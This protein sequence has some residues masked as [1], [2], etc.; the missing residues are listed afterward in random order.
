MCILFRNGIEIW[1]DEEKALRFMEHYEKNQGQGL[2]RIEGRFINLVEIVGVFY[3]QDLEDNKRRKKGEWKCKY[4]NW[5]LKEEVCYCGRD[6]GLKLTSETI[7][8]NKE[9]SEDQRL[10][11]IKMLEDMRKEIDNGVLTSQK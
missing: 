11:N 2:A 4:N 6:L 9:I 3:P 5:H 1:I 8:K 10:K 7:K